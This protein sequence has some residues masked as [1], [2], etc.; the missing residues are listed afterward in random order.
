MEKKNRE[1]P[2]KKKKKKKDSFQ[3]YLNRQ[4]KNELWL[5]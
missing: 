2:K 1:E 4:K 3:S 5:A